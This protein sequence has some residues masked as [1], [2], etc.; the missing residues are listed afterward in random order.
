MLPEGAHPGLCK[1]QAAKIQSYIWKPYFAFRAPE[2]LPF[3]VI[4]W[5][6]K[7]FS[8][9]GRCEA[10]CVHCSEEE[11]VGQISTGSRRPQPA[12]ALCSVW[13]G[14]GLSPTS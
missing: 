9:A 7:K 4:H 13:S 5:E 11:D 3:Q 8:S 12:P 10:W 6:E 14:S 1:L 2:D